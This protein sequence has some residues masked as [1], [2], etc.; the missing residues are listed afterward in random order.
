MLKVVGASW[1][2][3]K[4]SSMIVFS[5]FLLAIGALF[6]L[7]IER[8]LF[9]HVY[10]ST[11]YWTNAAGFRLEFWGQGNKIVD[12]PKGAARICYKD[13]IQLDEWP[14]MEIESNAHYPDRVQAFAAG[15]LE[16]ALTWK[17]IY[18]HWAE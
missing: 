11:A 6:I 1:Y 18:N 10:C 9:D 15:A 5:A 8:P 12:I 13:G 17:T 4:I 14:H 7:N 3:T 16:G 2:Q